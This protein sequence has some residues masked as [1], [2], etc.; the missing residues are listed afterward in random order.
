VLYRALAPRCGLGLMRGKPGAA[1]GRAPRH[2]HG[3]AGAFSEL[4]ASGRLKNHAAPH[5]PQNAPR[6]SSR[7]RLSDKPR[8]PPRLPDVLT[9][10]KQAHAQGPAIGAEEKRA[11]RRTNTSASGGTRHEKLSRCT[12]RR[13]A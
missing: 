1:A 11:A 2:Q 13:A 5:S 9:F 10:I 6:R 7:P 8:G 4:A 12:G 3:W